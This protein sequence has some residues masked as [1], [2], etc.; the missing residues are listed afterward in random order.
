M[1]NF[2]SKPK[3]DLEQETLFKNWEQ[4][5]GSIVMVVGNDIYATKKAKNASKMLKEIE[6]KHHKQPLI[7]YVPKEGTL[8][9]VLT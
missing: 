5:R 7:T 3:L 4:Y 2:K 1:A 6:K 9:L 8:I